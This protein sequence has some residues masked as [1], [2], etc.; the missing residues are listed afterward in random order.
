MA[1]LEP[2]LEAQ[3]S[4]LLFRNALCEKQNKKH[5]N[6]N[7]KSQ[8]KTYRQQSQVGGEGSLRTKG[9][10]QSP[11]MEAVKKSLTTKGDVREKLVLFCRG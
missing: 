5:T 10:I 9:R 7:C 1:W 11:F 6:I 3:Y 4:T 2:L 8:T